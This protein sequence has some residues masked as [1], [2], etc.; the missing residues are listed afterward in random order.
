MAI[1]GTNQFTVTRNDIID[2]ALRTLGVIGIGETPQTED[3]TNCSQALNIMIKS[4]AKKGWPLWTVETLGIVMVEAAEVYPIGPTAGYVFSVTITD[5]GTGYPNSGTVT[6]TDTEDGDLATAT[7]TASG[8]VIQSV[9]I[10][11]AGSTYSYNTTCTFSGGGTGATGTVGVV[12]LTTIK[13]VRAF[14]GYIRDNNEN[15][16]VLLPISKDEY[17]SL[18]DKTSAGIPNQFYYDNQLAAGYMY[19][20]NVPDSNSAGYTIYLD[21]QRMFDDMTTGSNDFD[22]PQEWFQALKWGLCAEV[23]VEYGIDIQLVP[24]Y[25]EKASKY[26][27]DSFDFSVE[28]SSVYFTMDYQGFIK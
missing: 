26:I 28:E 16:T 25:E 22:F 13:P 19:V 24:Y 18:G 14:T 23:A 6:I 17:D 8:G 27:S 20:Y 10:T 15:D 4:W 21:A 11:N 5:G 12:G 2:S 9:T 1:S 7:Y 3:Y